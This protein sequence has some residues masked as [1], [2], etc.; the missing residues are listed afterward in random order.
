M[1]VCVCVTLVSLVLYTL[2]P[3]SQEPLTRN[4]FL[5]FFILFRVQR[6]TSD[7]Y[8]SDIHCTHYRLWV[9]L[10]LLAIVRSRISEPRFVFSIIC[11]DCLMTSRTGTPSVTYR[12][13]S[14]TDGQNRPTD[15]RTV[16]YAAGKIKGT[17]YPEGLEQCRHTVAFYFQGLV[18]SENLAE[19]E[20]T[21]YSNLPRLF[22]HALDLWASISFERFSLRDKLQRC[23]L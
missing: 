9:R 4:C 23:F 17:E 8:K 6:G 5:F 10:S 11:C 20:R 19:A 3:E 15:T 14:P 13:R 2:C 1:C 7:R 21:V 12:S 18:T 22:R 16:R